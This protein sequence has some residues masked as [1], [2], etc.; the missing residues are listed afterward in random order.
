GS[1]VANAAIAASAGGSWRARCFLYAAGD[2]VKVANNRGPKMKS[3]LQPPKHLKTIILFAALT[4]PAFTSG[5]G[6]A[7]SGSPQTTTSSP[8][9][10]PT[11]TPSP[12]PTPTPTPT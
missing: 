8:T 5:C 7:L 3:L 2:E 10:T 9:A 11:P 6:G 12:T 1:S 4:V